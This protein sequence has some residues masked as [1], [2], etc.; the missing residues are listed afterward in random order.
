MLITRYPSYHILDAMATTFVKQYCRISRCILG[1]VFGAIRGV[2]AWDIGLLPGRYSPPGSKRRIDGGFY[3]SQSG[4]RS[5][6]HSAGRE[7]AD[8]A[9]LHDEEHQGDWNRG[10]HGGR[11]HI[12]I[13]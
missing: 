1:I 2:Q 9:F 11:G 4:D 6:L 3:S 5:L 8:E 12:V 13:V 10:H 7:A